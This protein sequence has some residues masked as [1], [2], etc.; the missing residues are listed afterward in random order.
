MKTAEC[1]FTLS[2]VR[3]VK[4]GRW[5]D[6]L[7]THAKTC[8]SCSDTVRVTTMFVRLSDKDDDHRLPEYL[9]LWLRAQ[10]ARREE[11]L[12]RLDLIALGGLSISVV[13]GLAGIALGASSRV[14]NRVLDAGRDI[15]PVVQQGLAH[16]AP[17]VLIIGVILLLWL[18][19]GDATF[20]DKR[21]E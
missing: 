20:L 17:I 8:S 1:E 5:S 10:F 3:A 21:Q 2:V 4:S 13:I 11:K 12:S 6:D 18:L 19:T 9:S 16:G 14:F 7:R 15:S